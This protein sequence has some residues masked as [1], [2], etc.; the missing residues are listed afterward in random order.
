MCLYKFVTG[1]MNFFPPEIDEIILSELS[2][3]FKAMWRYSLTCKSNSY[4]RD[5]CIDYLGQIGIAPD[6]FV[7]RALEH[8]KLATLQK[9]LFSDVDYV[10][11]GCMAKCVICKK[12]STCITIQCPDQRCVIDERCCKKMQHNICSYDNMSLCFADTYRVAL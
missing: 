6:E 8:S 12:V 4:I 10:P 2:S 1:A 5:N 3:D 11:V 7:I 9:I